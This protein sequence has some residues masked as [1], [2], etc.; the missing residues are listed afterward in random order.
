M[1]DYMLI[2]RDLPDEQAGIPPAEMQR[3]IQRY[4][5]WAGSLRAGGQY[6][7]GD[8]LVDGA[9]RVMRRG[10]KA[11]RVTDGPFAEGKEV[12][13]GFFTVKADSL[14]EA[15]R[16]AEGCP[17]LDAGGSLEVREIEAL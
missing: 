10:R 7:A 3:N 14:D 8:K 17:H 13:G 15:V 6:V 5:A 12:I 2:L 4:M 9:G 11:L 16:I 1:P